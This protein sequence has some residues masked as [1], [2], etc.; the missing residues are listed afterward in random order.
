MKGSQNVQIKVWV[1]M[2]NRIKDVRVNE[3]GVEGGSRHVVYV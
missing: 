2:K 1:F 3:E